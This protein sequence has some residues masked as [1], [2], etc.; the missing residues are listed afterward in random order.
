VPVIHS[1]I[2]LIGPT[3]TFLRYLH[4]YQRYH[5]HDYALKFASSQREQAEKR[6]VSNFFNDVLQFV[7]ERVL[8][9][10]GKAGST[11]KCL[12]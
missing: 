12:D 3:L 11:T 6:M 5:G 1:L 8:F 10:G 4:Y 2:A 9:V 7:V